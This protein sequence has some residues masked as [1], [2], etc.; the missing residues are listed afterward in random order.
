MSVELTPMIFFKK[1]GLSSCFVGF[2]DGALIAID[3]QMPRDLRDFQSK[4]PFEKNLSGSRVHGK[5]LTT[6]RNTIYGIYGVTWL[7]GSNIL[8]IPW[9][10]T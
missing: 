8:Y 9:I 1:R 2:L 3:F 4:H 5:K 6:R 10:C 7:Q